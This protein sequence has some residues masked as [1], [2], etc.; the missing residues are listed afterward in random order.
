MEVR[1]PFVNPAQDVYTIGKIVYFAGYLALVQFSSQSGSASYLGW[2][3]FFSDV[4]KPLG[5]AALHDK[6]VTPGKF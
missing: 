1:N 5:W 2:I 3:S 6:K 4:P